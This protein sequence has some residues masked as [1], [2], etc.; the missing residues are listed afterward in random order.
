MGFRFCSCRV[1][2]RRTGHVLKLQ[3]N[4]NGYVKVTL[5]KNGKNKHWYLHRLVMDNFVGICPSHKEVN[6]KDCIKSHN[7]IKNLEYVTK[8]RNAKHAYE[9]GR[10]A[11]G[12]KHHL[13]TFTNK[14]IKKIRK[15]YLTGAYTQKEISIMFNM[16]R[17]YISLIVNQKVRQYG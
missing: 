2:N 12:E 11:S 6:H 4:R 7:H 15:M 10:K 1:K 16:T 9:N 17:E 14:E 5:C 13:S 8:S 3:V